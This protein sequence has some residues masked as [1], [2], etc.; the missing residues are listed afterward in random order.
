MTIIKCDNYDVLC[1]NL[2]ISIIIPIYNADDYIEK[3]VNSILNQTYKN[4]EIILIDD[5]S[6]D[7][8]LAICN[9]YASKNENI[10]VIH[11]ENG[12]PSRAR[13]IGI[14]NASGE[15]ILFIDADDVIKNDMIEK[16][17]LIC[18]DADVV[19]CSYYQCKNY[20]KLDKD[21]I[22]FDHK[23]G[24]NIFKEG[25]IKNIFVKGFYTNNIVGLWSMWNKLYK[26]NFI[27]KNDII[28]NESLIRAED[29]WFN[30]DIFCYAQKV[31]TTSEPLY[32][33]M[34]VNDNSIMHRI[35]YSQYDEWVNNRKK[36]LQ[37]NEIL[38]IK[39]DYCVFYK[40]FLY[41]VSVYI[42]Y[43]A[44]QKEKEKIYKILQDKFYLENLKYGKLL[45]IHLRFINLCA[46]YNTHLSY[47]IYKLWGKIK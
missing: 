4:Y 5:G 9:N 26:R 35:R 25:Q 47:I 7:N 40:N 46:K 42:R 6:T 17:V 22:V 32:Y 37:K 41:N 31:I 11:I 14:K 34:Q 12:G 30:F 39:I 36:L 15:Y 29:F 20:Q 44:Q 33:Y 43:L 13:N 8:S 24:N 27:K 45:P 16:L 3:C 2:K 23:L 19:M 1:E 38:K 18:D 28:L 21:K 10:K